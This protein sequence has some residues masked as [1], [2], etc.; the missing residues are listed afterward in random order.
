MAKNKRNKICKR[1]KEALRLRE[2]FP[3]RLKI[4]RAFPD[5][6]D[7]LNYINSLIRDLE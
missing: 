6:K 5:P 7:A 2:L 1:I 3:M 4:E